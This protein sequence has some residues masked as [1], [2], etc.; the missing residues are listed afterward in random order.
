MS[1]IINKQW[2]SLGEFYLNYNGRLKTREKISFG[3]GVIQIGKN[4]I[5]EPGVII[6][7]DVVI[8]NDCVLAP[9][10]LIRDGCVIG[11]NTIIGAMTNLCGNNKVGSFTTIHDQ[12]HVTNGMEIG[13]NV[14]IGPHLTTVNTPKI[15]P[16]NAKF[17]YPNSTD[18]PRKIPKILD[19][20]QIGGKVTIAPGVMV[21]AGSIIGMNVFLKRDVPP[22]KKVVADS[23]WDEGWLDE[24]K[25]KN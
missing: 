18:M 14:F 6:Y 9:G 12:C 5:I 11:N 17:G 4:V 16:K 1:K 24:P 15:G 22:N 25:T 10:C 2:E 19:N 23:T 8:G 3:K 21:G 7:P 13:N 20:V